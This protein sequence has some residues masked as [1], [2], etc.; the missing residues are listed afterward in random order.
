MSTLRETA[1]RVALE[2]VG[3]ASD[4][5]SAKPDTLRRWTDNLTAAVKAD[6]CEWTDAGHG[7]YKPGCQK[8]ATFTAW[9]KEWFLRQGWQGCPYCIRKVRLMP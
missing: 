1:A 4:D 2:M 8:V 3:L 5:L 7:C 6:V 9:R